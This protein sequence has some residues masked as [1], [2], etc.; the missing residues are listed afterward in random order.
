LIAE[1]LSLGGRRWA[2]RPQVR[3]LAPGARLVERCLAVRPPPVDDAAWLH[4]TLEHITAAD[5]LLMRGMDRAL[6]RLRAA[7]AGGERIL[8]VTDYDVDG[9]T[10]S[11]ILQ[12]ALRLASPGPVDLRW[13]IP[14][15]FDEGYGF[16][17]AAVERAKREGVQ[18]IVTADIGV[19]DHVPVA[20]AAAAGIDVIVCDHHLPDGESVPEAALAVLCPPQQGCA[21]PNKALA[22]CGVSLKLAQAL[23]ADHPRREAVLRSFLKL[24]AI[25]TVA[26]MVPLDN[27]ENRAIVALGLAELSRGQHQPG[28]GALLEASGLKP[29]EPIE[30]WQLGFHVGPRI[31]AAGRL[32]HAGLVV[33]LL[34]ERDPAAAR[35]RAERLSALNRDRQALQHEAEREAL[36]AVPSPTPAF[37][38]VSG[39]ESL[40]GETPW[41]RGVVGIVAGKLKDQLHRPVAVVAMS[42]DR[43]RGSVRSIPGVHAVRG[44]E[45]ARDLLVRFGGH[46]FAAG[47]EVLRADLPA[48][49]ARLDAWAAALDDGDLFVPQDLAD[50]ALTASELDLSAVEEL[51][52]LGPFGKGNEEPLFVLRGVLAQDVRRMGREDAHLRFLVGRAKAVWFRAPP[53]AEPALR[54]RVDLLVQ[55]GVDTWQGRRSLSLKVQDLRLAPPA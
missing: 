24:A 15:R 10:S 6:Q 27:L 44:L 23:L 29:G 19:R 36:A 33:E 34:N 16:T 25:G 48:L 21:Y 50:A 22:A 47:F 11:L 39:E 55:L 31:N 5:P 46:P 37:V 17:M 4:P 42:G 26:D 32:E 20:A 51:A 54:E 12:H 18:L 9:T 3:P 45:A 30:A 8:V 35:V 53:E 13:H 41:H 2:L 7:L 14:D 28:L 1:E 52:Q 40:S 38:V 49:A 43:G